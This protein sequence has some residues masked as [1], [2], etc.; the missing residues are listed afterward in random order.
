[1]YKPGGEERFQPERGNQRR[2]MTRLEHTRFRIADRRDWMID[3]KHKDPA[4]AER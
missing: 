2:N 4:T 1:M 3:Y